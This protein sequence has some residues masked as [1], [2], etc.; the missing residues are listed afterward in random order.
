MVL[1]SFNLFIYLLT[2]KRELNKKTGTGPIVKEVF[3]ELCRVIPWSRV[4]PDIE[5]EKGLD[6]SNTVLVFPGEESITT[7]ELKSIENFIILDGTW[8][9]AK[10]IYNRTPYLKRYNSYSFPNSIKSNYILRRNQKS[11][12]LCTV[13][14]VIE[15]CE[16]KNENFY[17]EK[18]VLAFK[19]FNN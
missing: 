16:I 2:H 10:K 14:S 3:K 9:E 1:G 8:Q 13:E 17:K 18:L 11:F 5:L 7:T 12:G 4:E 6:P 15:L 19:T